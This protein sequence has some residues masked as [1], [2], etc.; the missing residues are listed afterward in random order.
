MRTPKRNVYANGTVA[1]KVRFRIYG[2]DSSITFKGPPEIEQETK[3][4]AREFAG[5][6]DAIGAEA[7]LEWQ[8]RNDTEG[9][10]ADCPTMDEWAE[11]YFSTLTKASE[12][13]KHGY[14]R[15]WAN[16]FGS[17]LGHLRLDKITRREIAHAVNHL[18]T[19]GKRDGTGYSDKS[20]LNA[21]TNL[22][23]MFDRAVYDRLIPANPCE[24]VELPERTG[25]KAD[26]MFLFTLDEYDAFVRAFHP[27]YQPLV[28]L[29]AGTG[30][31]WGEVEALEVSDVNLDLKTL[32]INKAA[33][34]DTSRS[35]RAI[36][37]TKTKNRN[38]TVTLPDE[39][40]EAIRPVVEGRPRS[41]RLFTA[42]RGG[43]LRYKTFWLEWVKTCAEIGLDPRPRGPHDLR[44][45]HA[46]WLIALG[47]PLPVIQKRLGH[48]S[49]TVTVDIYGHLSPDIQRAAADAASMFFSGRDAL[50]NANAAAALE[51]AEAS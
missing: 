15:D 31:S 16:M 3:A 28:E 10:A 38:R 19:Q 9:A 46:S 13:T 26:D 7:A 48:H 43:P 50:P 11:D 1:Y 25:H 51:S 41:A 18:A 14:R 40:V 6:V 30:A 21:Y 5:M 32:R 4:A 17:Q 20:M 27:H 47:V 37:P 44:H 34:W 29:I 8:R 23:A 2:E 42:P 35:D 22:S 12:G 49:I 39:T 45:S 36:G 24:T 33:K